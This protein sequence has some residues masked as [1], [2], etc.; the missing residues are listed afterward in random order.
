ML[1]LGI[2]SSVLGLASVASTLAVLWLAFLKMLLLKNMVFT[3]VVLIFLRLS[4]VFYTVSLF[5]LF[6]VTTLNL[7]LIY[8]LKSWYSKSYLQ[9]KT[10][11]ALSSFI[12]HVRQ[13]VRQ[14]G[15]VSPRFLNFV[16]L[17]FLRILLLC[18][19]LG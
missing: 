12:V 17:V 16:F 8:L 14:G 19:L 6:I 11:G 18:F 1:I 15:V 9:I 3:F 5:I 4:V 2:T 13:G 10:N 7:P